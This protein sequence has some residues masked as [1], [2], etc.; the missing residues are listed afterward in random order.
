MDP[1]EPKV[2]LL[3]TPGKQYSAG[4]AALRNLSE[5]EEPPV[6]PDDQGMLT[7]IKNLATYMSDLAVTFLGFARDAEASALVLGEDLD[8]LHIRTEAA[9]GRLVRDEDTTYAFSQVRQWIEQ[10]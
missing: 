4:Q 10:L 6:A 8:R 3:G 5:L 2:L 9:H 1:H 7:Y